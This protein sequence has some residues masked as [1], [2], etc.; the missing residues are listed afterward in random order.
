MG[1]KVLLAP[2]KWQVELPDGRPAA[3]Y[4]IFTYEAGTVTKAVTYTDASGLT[5]NTNPII[6]DSRGEASVWVESANPDSLNVLPPGPPGPP[7]TQGPPGPQGSPGAPGLSNEPSVTVDL[8][9]QQIMNLNEAGGA[10][11]ILPPP[12]LGFY[13]AANLFVFQSSIVGNPM[14]NSFGGDLTL[15]YGTDTTGLPVLKTPMPLNVPNI[16]TQSA[17]AVDAFLTRVGQGFGFSGTAFPG[18]SFV[19]LTDVTAKGIVLASSTQW[20]AVQTAGPIYKLRIHSGAAGTGYAVNDVGTIGGGGTG[21]TYKVLTV[22]SGAPTSIQLT[23]AGTG[24]NNTFNA[25]TTATSGAGTGLHVDIFV[26][27]GNN[28]QL[29]VSAYYRLVPVQ[30]LSGGILTLGPA[31]GSHLGSGYAVG[32]TGII[33]A[34]NLNATYIVDAV[35]G[36]AISGFHLTYIGSGYVPADNVPTATGGSQP[37][38]GTGFQIRILS[39]T[40]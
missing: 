2:V 22:A 10:V 12:P 30:N 6:L 21:G 14:D 31:T 34:G 32:D 25:A 8:T 36:G 9:I 24:Y 3:G 17:N 26:I 37:G 7:G 33:N 27:T 18:A 19:P 4:K 20:A 40:P 35:S 28:T 11:Q 16:L 29:R 13:Y 23:A 39:V 15:Y 1:N 5:P 38:S